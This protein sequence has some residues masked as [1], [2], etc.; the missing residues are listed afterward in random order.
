MANMAARANAIG[1]T[2]S[3]SVKAAHMDTTAY[4]LHAIRNPIH[5]ATDSY[6]K[7]KHIHRQK[8]TCPLIQIYTFAKGQ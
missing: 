7:R 8:Y 4:G 1:G 3:G 2:K 5:T 6:M